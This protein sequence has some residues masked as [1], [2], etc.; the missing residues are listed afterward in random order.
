M[1]ELTH[2]SPINWKKKEGGEKASI[3]ISKNSSCTYTLRR[4]KSSI[5]LLEGSRVGGVSEKKGRD[6]GTREGA[7]HLAYTRQGYKRAG[8][9]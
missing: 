3:G 7:H 2:L 5:T 6:S 9:T 8:S 4:K 1:G